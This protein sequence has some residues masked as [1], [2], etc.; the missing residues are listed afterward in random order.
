MGVFRITSYNVCY[1]KLLRLD[2]TSLKQ[3]TSKSVDFFLTAGYGKIL[4]QSW[5]TFPKNGSLNL[6]FSLLPAYRGANPA[7]WAIMIGEKRTGITLMQM[8]QK[9][10]GG[11]IIEQRE[12]PISSTRNNFV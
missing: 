10:D 3:L 4:P 11:D 7:E 9:L 2:D 6:H 1:T 8:N 5:L 12:L